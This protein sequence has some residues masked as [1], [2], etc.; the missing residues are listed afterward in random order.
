MMSR[1]R[2]PCRPASVLGAV[3]ASLLLVNCAGC[4]GCRRSTADPYAPWGG[5]SK[6]EWLKKRQERLE[7]ERQEEAKA[8]AA[9][10]AARKKA[11]EER[12]ARR[13]KEMET[14]T[15]AAPAAKL[16]AAAPKP[17]ALPDDFRLWKDEHYLAAREANDPRLTSA[18]VWRG[19]SGRGKSGEVKFF[20][21][22]LREA[23]SGSSLPS[24]RPMGAGS[25][26]LAPG[27]IQAVAEAVAIN[28][29]PE[30]C[31]ALQAFLAG[32][33]IPSGE[34]RQTAEAVINA[35]A[36]H[37][38]Q[39]N[40]DL[41]LGVVTE[42][43]RVCPPGRPDLSAE[44]LR[45]L[46][47]AAVRASPH[48]RLRTALAERLASGQGSAELRAAAGPLLL[49]PQPVN[50]EAQAVLY[51]ADLLPAAL[52]R[53][54]EQQLAG[55]LSQALAWAV[56]AEPP[57]GSQIPT[58]T[59]KAAE[60]AVLEPSTSI[61]I[62]Q[63]VWSAQ[64]GRVLEIRLASV[65]SL[66]EEA[67]LVAL[68]SMVPRQEVRHRLVRTLR[69][70]LHEGPAAV[71]S[72]GLN[73]Q[74]IPEPGFLG[75]LRHA[76]A[77]WEDAAPRAGST[78]W[79]VANEARGWPRSATAPPNPAPSWLDF[80]QESLRAQLARF[81][82]AAL[83]AAL[84]GESSA[85]GGTGDTVAAPIAFHQKAAPVAML[86]LLLPRP[87]PAPDAPALPEPLQ[88]F[89]VRLEGP[90]VP[91]K[92]L[93]HYRRQFGPKAETRYGPQVAWL[94]ALLPA[95][96]SWDWTTVDVWLTLPAKETGLPKNGVPSGAAV[97]L[98][99]EILWVRVGGDGPEPPA[100]P[101]PSPDNANTSAPASV[102]G[103]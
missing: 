37:P 15:A 46:G 9:N 13:R 25:G 10:E 20:L 49:E 44:E 76:R 42:P 80:E 97:E 61:A 23:P 89:Y 31:E 72:A 58:P 34:S 100:G 60:I 87:G 29:T 21:R 48:P 24:G 17:P 74:V 88:V 81:H 53:N 69:R 50:I 83:K 86:H 95:D 66:T 67:S 8:K 1:A 40:Q 32:K 78:R 102:E 77:G 96:G 51:A 98:T 79:P 52:R 28:E 33:G 59:G 35:L 62:A 6:E 4:G 36:A 54:V 75:V 63:R 14:H 99:V 38:V 94:A 68:A 12:L 27:L 101:K 47:L 18:V 64:W 3:L 22:L 70:H 2:K 71:R 84:R 93:A 56:G 85:G 57:A 26:R 30:A 19:R 91:E 73:A 55:S 45:R 90:G 43:Q 103:K 39:N 11:A 7:K 16:A 92:V 65:S 5:M 82:H 41:L